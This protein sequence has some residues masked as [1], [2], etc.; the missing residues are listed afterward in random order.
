VTRTI[1]RGGD[2]VLPDRLA[3]RHALI[4][5][6]GRVVEIVADASAGAAGDQIVDASDCVIV[7]G[8]V[9]VHVHGVAGH[10]VLDGAGVVERI[11]RMLPRFGV[12]AFCPTSVACSAGSLEV[13]LREVA[14]LRTAGGPGARVIGAH[15]ESGF[16]NEAFRGAQPAEW[17][18]T[19]AEGSEILAAIRRHREAVAIVTLAPEIEGGQE[20]IG[21]LVRE[22]MRVSL[23]HS[24]ATWEQAQAAFQS[25][26]ARVTHL[27][28]R[29]R[30]MDHREPGL[31]GAALA[32]EAVVV[33]LIGDGQHIHPAILR[34]VWAAK[35][36]ARVVAVTDGTAGSGLSRGSVAQLGG[37]PVRVD[38]VARLDDGT[39]AGSVA[40][41]D[42]VVSRWVN[43]VRVGIVDAVAMCATTP[44]ADVRR[45][46]LGRLVPGGH[47]DCVVLDRQLRVRETWIAGARVYQK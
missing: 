34:T 40:T 11:S 41:M 20:L 28:N 10:D 3:D 26:A 17:V 44:A 8:L 30:P 23:G 6:A 18:R 21:Q 1:F 45:P 7:P 24:G 19:P 46:E 27:F 4:V 35:G 32:D 13:L 15:V 9:D 5:E 2:V 14:R 36:A 22:G 31:V 29:M 42:Q 39:I 43:E 47:A 38:D 37:R 33:E 12:T 16:I 25:G